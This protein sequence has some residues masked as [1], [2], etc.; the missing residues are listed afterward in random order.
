MQALKTKYS[1][2]KGLQDITPARR[3]QRAR[4]YEATALAIAQAGLDRWRRGAPG[5]LQD[6]Q[7]RRPDQDAEQPSRRPRND[8]LREDDYVWTQFIDNRILPVKGARKAAG[9]RG[10][11]ACC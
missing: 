7:V 9:R 2:I 1:D 3:A 5:L 11:C 6:R 10:R 8:A 4:W